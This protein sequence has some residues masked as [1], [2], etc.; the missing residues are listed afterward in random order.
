MKSTNLLFVWAAIILFLSSCENIRESSKYGLKEGFYKSRLAHKKMKKVYIV[1]GDDSIKIYTEK[2]LAKETVDTLHSLKI[3]FPATHK[4]GNFDSYSFRQNSFDVDV[5][6]VLFKYRPALKGFP[7]QFNTSVLNG[8]FYFGYR[9]DVYHL[10]YKETPLRIFKR[11]M[12]HYGFSY[13]VFSGLGASRIDEFV[14]QGGVN[15]QYDGFV[16]LTGIA[17][18]IAINKLS[19]GVN[20]GVDHLLDRN[21]HVWLYQGKPWV[22]ISVGLNLN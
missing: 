16:N 21:R 8:A 6:S 10:K 20:C 9:T 22:G 15:I 12:T 13:G 2:G 17:A 11:N 18:I 19:F 14:T 5:L 1:P 4:P 7:N 3:A